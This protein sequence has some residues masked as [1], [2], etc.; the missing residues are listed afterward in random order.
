MAAFLVDFT[1]MY[2]VPQSWLRPYPVFESRAMSYA[3]GTDVIDLQTAFRNRDAV[4]RFS[5]IGKVTEM[6]VRCNPQRL[7]ATSYRFLERVHHEGMLAQPCQ[8][9][10]HL[11][12]RELLIIQL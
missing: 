12:R 5:I 8:A 11:H 1:V 10:S 2:A 3:A 7:L 4:N 6:D 9:N